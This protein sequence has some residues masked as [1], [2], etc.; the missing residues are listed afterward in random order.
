ML[1]PVLCR[2]L[3]QLCVQKQQRHSDLHSRRPGSCYGTVHTSVM[4]L[5]M[6]LRSQETIKGMMN[7]PSL[8]SQYQEL[9]LL[10]WTGTI[11]DL[12]GDSASGSSRDDLAGGEGIASGV[13]SSH[14]AGQ[15][16]A[17]NFTRDT[18]HIIKWS[19][20]Q[21]IASCTS[22]GTHPT[23]LPFQSDSG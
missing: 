2:P 3:R 22:V 12:A 1:R 4:C 13:C 15:K 5:K 6:R 10:L 21:H 17:D 18:K 19:H 23:T 16:L 11:L 7:C 20:F 8:H 14:T 9:R